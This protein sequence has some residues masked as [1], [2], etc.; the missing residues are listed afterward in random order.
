MYSNP[1]YLTV[2]SQHEENYSLF[3]SK[4]R[5]TEL[6]PDDDHPSLLEGEQQKLSS[7]TQFT[8]VTD[9]SAAVP[10]LSGSA[11]NLGG[12][13]KTI[14]PNTEFKFQ[15]IVW[16]ICHVNVLHRLHNCTFLFSDDG[17]AHA[18]RIFGNKNVKVTAG[19]GT[20]D[21]LVEHTVHIAH[22]ATKDYNRVSKNEYLEDYL[23][24]AKLHI[25]L[26]SVSGHN[27][28]GP[29]GGVAAAI[30]FMT[31]AMNKKVRPKT[32]I[33][34]RISLKGVVTE[35]SSIEPKF[36]AAKQAGMEHVLLPESNHLEEAN[37]FYF[38][39]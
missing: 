11:S 13:P 35:V 26:L 6:L 3:C 16:P 25:N 9:S 15:S 32:A 33:T 29:S 17:G 14:P 22:S 39:Y 5:S 36:L 20:L 31:M 38:N 18:E 34:S 27:K 4:C 23:D 12:V 19:G 24:K 7:S 8:T 37:D 1:S 28:S 10:H 2:C 30:C 21:Q